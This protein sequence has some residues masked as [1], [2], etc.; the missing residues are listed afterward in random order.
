MSNNDKNVECIIRTGL[1][2]PEAKAFCWLLK[3]KEGT[4]VEIERGADIRQPE[5]SLAMKCMKK[6]DW[7][8]CK[9]IP[10]REKG[11]PQNHYIFKTE[12]AISDIEK[13]IKEEID[14]IENSINRIKALLRS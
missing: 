4:S 12:K 6:R 11:R 7:V 5:V 2:R 13:K 14:S 10:Q 9:R 3:N 8:V 1:K